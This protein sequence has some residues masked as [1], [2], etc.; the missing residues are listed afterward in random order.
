M[1][2]RRGRDATQRPT[3]RVRVDG[4]E[5]VV[6]AGISLATALLLAGQRR[7]VRTQPAGAPG[8]V[9]CGMG[10]CYE[11]A[12]VIDGTGGVRTCIT[13]VADQMRIDT[14][15]GVGSGD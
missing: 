15:P 7:I 11:C 12:A 9:F 14:V 10:S 1:S 13:P 3:V 4:A 6:P 5:L 8:G 2:H